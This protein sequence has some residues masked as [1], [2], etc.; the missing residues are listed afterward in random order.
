MR[1]RSNQGA[2]LLAILAMVIIVTTTSFVAGISLNK[3]RIQNNLNNSKLLASAK[4]QLLGYALTQIPPGLLPCPDIDNDG[5]SDLAGLDCA[6][7]R[8]FLPYKTLNMK[9]NRDNESGIL[10][11]GVEAN[12]TRINAGVDLNSSLPTAL[13]VD[14]QDEVAAVVIAS[15]EAL[16]G[17]NRDESPNIVNFNVANY[18]EGINADADTSTYT[19]IPGDAT[20][21]ITLSITHSEF[22][23][24]V[25]KQVL[26]IIDDRIR[27]YANTANCNE[28]P[29]ASSDIAAPYDSTINQETGRIPYGL[30][31]AFGGAIGCPTTLNLPAWVE[32]NWAS[33]IHYAFCGPSGADCISI[34]G[35]LNQTSNAIII[36]PGNQLLGQVRPSN[37]LSDYFEGDNAIIDFQYEFQ[38]DVNHGSLF[39]DQLKIVFP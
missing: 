37:L 35:D 9:T 13:R 1:F 6:S 22:W 8:G 18:L 27:D 34:I 39:N 19:A 33:E 10:W 3:Q 32:D 26:S 25:E 16:V 21:D 15:R 29:W 20:N 5:F 2:A 28:V 7:Q 24:T 11:Y 36:A 4:T 30:A 23:N 38:R 12:Y 14:G 17:Q 31:S